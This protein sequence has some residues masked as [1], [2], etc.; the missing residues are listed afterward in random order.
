[1][2]DDPVAV[3]RRRLRVRFAERGAVRRFL[4]DYAAAEQGEDADLCA[5]GATRERCQRRLDRDDAVQARGLGDDPQLRGE[6]KRGRVDLVVEVG[7]H[8]V[9]GEGAD[10]HRE[11][12]QDHERQQRRDARQA[13]ADGQTVEARVG[14][15]D[16]P[17]EDANDPTREGRSP[18]L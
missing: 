16:C 3:N 17:F 18:L 13:H 12:A 10:R 2:A 14:A 9:H 15:R 6:L 11:G 7:A 4:D 8:A 5:V 1:M